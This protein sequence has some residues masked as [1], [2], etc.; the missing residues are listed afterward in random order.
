MS[1]LASGIKNDEMNGILIEIIIIQTLERGKGVPAYLPSATRG[2]LL[3]N[4]PG[5]RFLFDT[6][7]T[8]H[9]DSL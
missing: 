5:T 7:C 8:I 9:E 4:S 6:L 1:S 3:T 2:T